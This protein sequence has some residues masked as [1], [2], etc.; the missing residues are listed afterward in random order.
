MSIKRIQTRDSR[1]GKLL[2]RYQVVVYLPAAKGK[3][4]RVRRLCET[5]RQAVKVER[6]LMAAAVQPQEP[7]PPKREKPKKTKKTSPK[8]EEFAPRWIAY[9]RAEGNSEATMSEKESIIRVH[10][11][12][13]FRGLRL[14]EVTSKRVAEYRVAKSRSHRPKSI[15]N[16]L[17]VLH[18][19]LVVAQEWGEV[20]TLPKIPLIPKKALLSKVINFLTFDEADAYLEMVE[21]LYS[22]TDHLYVLLALRSGL[23]TGELRALTWKQI[24]FD[25][26]FVLV[27]RN[28]TDPA[29]KR[30]VAEGVELDPGIR[31]PKWN[32]I[33]Q[34]PLPWDVLAALQRAEG[35]S[36]SRLVFPGNFA[37]GF[38]SRSSI[39]KM[40]VRAAERGGLDKHVHPHMLRHTYA[41]HLVMRGVNL[42]VVQELLGHSTLE[43][44]M[45]YSHLTVDHKAD[46][47][48]VLAQRDGLRVIQGGADATPNRHQT[49]REL[50]GRR[51][52]K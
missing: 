39:E 16:H 46:A 27:N 41:S 30:D 15:S 51:R 2:R 29:Y 8:F 7:P 42:K 52:R 43:M 48:Q 12:P 49:G 20:E 37:G 50:A 35:A 28:L 36:R 25:E 32:K 3:R 19:M 6:E 22:A 5:R 34:V 13:A 14:D 10:L 4:K 24:D 38:R 18:R 17:A 40:V 1:T 23:R 45:R 21:R 31:L 11:R 26:G 9:Q 44:T 33:R 47:V